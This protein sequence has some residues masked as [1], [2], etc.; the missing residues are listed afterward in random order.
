METI[1]D[2]NWQVYIIICS[3][4]SLYTGITTD[5]ERRLSQ[6]KSGRGA[7]YLRSRQPVQLIYLE[8][9]LNLSTAIRKE[10]SIKKM[11]RSKKCLLI[12][13]RTNELREAMAISTA[14]WFHFCGRQVTLP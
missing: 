11:K 6:H 5:A 14:P 4:K 1:I 12:S 10:A 9:G 13:S 2:M 8:S 3:D 7:K